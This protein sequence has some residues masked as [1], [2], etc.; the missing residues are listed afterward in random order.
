VGRALQMMQAVP[1][2]IQGAKRELITG[3][4]SSYS[5]LF[6][7]CNGLVKRLEPCNQKRRMTVKAGVIA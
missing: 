4:R 5:P 6:L 2:Q 3:A 1:A 7:H